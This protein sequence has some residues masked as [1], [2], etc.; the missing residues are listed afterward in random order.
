MPGDI[1]SHVQVEQ[2]QTLP[3]FSDLDALLE[4]VVLGPS[5]LI[6]P[7]DSCDSHV[8]RT[9]K[10]R[11]SPQTP[12]ALSRSFHSDDVAVTCE[13]LDTQ[14]GKDS[15]PGRSDDAVIMSSVSDSHPIP[16]VPPMLTFQ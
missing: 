10:R 1:S 2:P 5:D 8:T 7:T 16:L 13:C 11:C 12:P 6:A 4:T 9:P 14:Q 15:L 3:S